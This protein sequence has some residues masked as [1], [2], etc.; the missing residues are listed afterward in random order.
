MSTPQPWNC[1]SGATGCNCLPLGA[2]RINESE[3]KRVLRKPVPVRLRA[4]RPSP[5]PSASASASPSA[6][7]PVPSAPNALP[8][9]GRPAS[10]I[11]P[12]HPMV[13]QRTLQPATV[14]APAP[15][16]VWV[17]PACGKCGTVLH[18]GAAVYVCLDTE[19]AKSG[20]KLCVSCERERAEFWGWG[21]SRERS[22]T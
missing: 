21:E 7:S 4:G 12:S 1:F 8:P 3:N 6:S 19:C 2:T 5:S 13:L 17:P 15:V 10:Y 20:Y 22:L 14:P 18:P 11:P 16:P 9:T